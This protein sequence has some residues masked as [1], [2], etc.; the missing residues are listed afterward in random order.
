M[1]FPGRA[2]RARLL[3][4]A[5]LLLAIPAT[6]DHAFAGPVKP[7]VRPDVSEAERKCLA[8]AIYFEARGEPKSGQ[9]AVAQVILNRVDTDA[10]PDT[11][12][13]VVYQ[14]KHRRNA[15]QFSFAC[16]GR[17]DV[18]RDTRAWAKAEAVTE[19]VLDGRGHVLQVS[20]ATHYHADYVSP[21]WAPKLKRLSKV[22][23]HIFYGV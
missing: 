18:P 23:R 14:N 22:G 12:C 16:D 2:R 15:C 17:P 3:L 8:T 4:A 7:P 9:A 10:Y 1:T 20:A 11:I 6:S 5:S 19:D 21:R 13:G